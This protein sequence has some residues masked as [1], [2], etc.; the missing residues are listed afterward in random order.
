[1]YKYPD[2]EE[3]K[4]DS[5][6]FNR[7]VCFIQVYQPGISLK[8]EV[9]DRDVKITPFNWDGS[10]RYLCDEL[11]DGAMQKNDGI[12]Q[13]FIVAGINRYQIFFD[14]QLKI[15]DLAVN[16]EFVSPGMLNSLLANK[17]SIQNVLAQG[18]LTDESLDKMIKD[19]QKFIIK[20]M[21]KMCI[22][23]QKN[24]PNYARIL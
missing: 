1:M 3:L 4:T 18:V 10:H 24:K 7:N 15:V 23:N 13:N 11:L 19:Y 2:I 5:L 14:D 22:D 9:I 20:P 8:T 16:Q 17:Y 12:L 6:L 21:T